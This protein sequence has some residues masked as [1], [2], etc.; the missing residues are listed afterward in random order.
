M[1]TQVLVSVAII[2][3]LCAPVFSANAPM[4][5]PAQALSSSK[6]N[7][8]LVIGP[9]DSLTA[10][11]N[12]SGAL[13]LIANVPPN[14]KAAEVEIFVDEKS[15]GT[16][17]ARPYRVEIDTATLSAGEHI[18]KAVAKDD[19][20]E[21]T[22]SASAKVNVGS[23][24]QSSNVHHAA[25]PVEPSVEPIVPAGSSEPVNR[26]GIPMEPNTTYTSDKHGFAINYPQGWSV[27]DETGKMGDK[28]SSDSLWL[29]IGMPP[30]VVNLHCKELASGTS[31]EVFAR[32]NPYV[33][34]WERRAVAGSPAFV[35]T[36]GKPELG[37][38]VHR[39]IFIKN[40][41]AWMANCIDTTGGDSNKTAKLLE[42]M[43]ESIRPTG[44]QVKVVPVK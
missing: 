3:G 2:S 19:S 24:S 30:V 12:V 28:K 5:P 17:N 26:P 27:K 15:V 44:P 31:A 18:I 21:Q 33:Q 25:K 37:R 39:I 8:A 11:K 1:K 32:Y 14:V 22:W 36:D 20:A 40:G 16:A 42:D 35:T 23:A 9:G 7:R 34:K 43:L 41:C 10:P 6:I 29:V 4:M 13:A 38:V